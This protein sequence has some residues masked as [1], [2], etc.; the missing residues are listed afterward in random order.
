MEII[1][2]KAIVSKKIYSQL[3]IQQAWNKEPEESD[4]LILPKLK[5]KFRATSSS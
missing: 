5:L 4:Q 2:D 1:I 3:E